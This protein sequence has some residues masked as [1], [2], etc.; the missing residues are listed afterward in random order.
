MRNFVRVAQLALV[1]GFAL[2]AAGT[3]PVAEAAA[4]LDARLRGTYAF[5]TAR[6]CTVSSAPF[7]GPTFAI[8]V[9][10]PPAPPV[11]VFRQTASDS[12]ILTFNG[13]GTGTSTGRS[14]TMNITSTG[15][16][17]LSISDFTRV[18]AYTVNPD[19]TVDTSGSATFETVFGS[20]TGT[21]G[22][23]SGQ[24]GRSQISHGNT[25]LVSAPQA[26][27]AV[28]TLVLTPPPP[29]VPFTQYRICVRSQTATMLP[30]H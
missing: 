22:T 6:T 25:M 26:Q 4:N 28:E 11:S 21:T 16:S 7:V 12:G 9:S 15:G 1:P 18:I 24:V 2:I 14:S 13:D 3:A 29:G 23:T 5:T 20:G 19:G 30:S 17:P 8:P 10:V 27:V